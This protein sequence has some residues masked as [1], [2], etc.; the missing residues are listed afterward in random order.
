MKPAI[1]DIFACVMERLDI[2]KSLEH[3]CCVT[4]ERYLVFF[5]FLEGRAPPACFSI[6]NQCSCSQIL[7]PGTQAERIASLEEQLATEKLRLQKT[8][9]NV[10]QAQ[11]ILL[12]AQTA[13]DEL[14]GDSDDLTAD[15]FMDEEQEAPDTE[16]ALAKFRELVH[17][18]VTRALWPCPSCAG[19]IVLR[20]LTRTSS[21][22]HH[23]KRDEIYNSL[24]SCAQIHSDVSSIQNFRFKGSS[25]EKWDKLEKIPAWQLTKVGNKKR[26]DRRS[27][28]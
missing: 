27:K 5:F 26:S 10:Q 18:T 20:S 19:G 2:R 12:A 17:E 8:T 7:R 25:G 16:L 24:Q 9:L 22:S 3:H 6:R 4:V 14:K 28:N 23:R 11:Q 15:D 13:A 1:R 21:R